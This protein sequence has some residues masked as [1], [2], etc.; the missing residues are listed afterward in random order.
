M[1]YSTSSMPTSPTSAAGEAGD[2][3]VKDAHDAGDDGLQD[4]ANAV[5]DGHEASTDGL[6]DRL[7]LEGC[8]S[9]RA[10]KWAGRKGRKTHAG[11]NSTHFEGLA[12]DLR[13]R[14]DVGIKLCEHAENVNR[15]TGSFRMIWRT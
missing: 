10:W 4:G 7:D 5:D 6:E 15:A 8:V 13:M 11:N 3:D 9:Q 2:D 14:L 12:V 1:L